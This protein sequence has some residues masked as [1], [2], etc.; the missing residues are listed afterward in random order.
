MKEKSKMEIVGYCLIGLGIL[1]FLLSWV[2]VDVTGVAEGPVILGVIGG[3]LLYLQNAQ[4][5]V[6]DFDGSLDEGEILLKSASVSVKRSMWDSKPESGSFILTNRRLLYSGTAGERD[7]GSHDFEYLLG[8]ISSVETK[9]P[10]FIII[11]DKNM[12]EHKLI[13]FG[14]KKWKDE[15]LKA[16]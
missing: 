6:A 2:G 11:R 7:V 14:K 4:D 13:A 5:K 3:F 16:L 10:T 12:N 9:F 15:I 8:E 1:D